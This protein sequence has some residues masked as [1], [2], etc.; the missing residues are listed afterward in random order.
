[1]SVEW[2][3]LAASALTDLEEALAARDDSVSLGRLRESLK[4]L[5]TAYDLLEQ[6]EGD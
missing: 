6:Q 5:E 4:N 3:K 1:M 2:R